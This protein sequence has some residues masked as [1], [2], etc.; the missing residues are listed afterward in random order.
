M[1]IAL[2]EKLC[3]TLIQEAQI[4]REYVQWMRN[5]ATER[6]STRRRCQISKESAE[7]KQK[8]RERMWPASFSVRIDSN[9]R[10]YTTRTVHT[11][12]DTH[13]SVSSTHRQHV[14][15]KH[16][17][18]KRTR[19]DRKNKNKIKHC[20]RVIQAALKLCALRPLYS[21]REAEPSHRTPTQ[22]R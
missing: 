14:R 4:Q 11:H 15:R 12:T 19:R 6:T 5:R 20:Q 18:Q 8:E 22:Q 17:K 3:R 10:W 2:T 7:R 16:G 1:C 21:K 13:T 9:A